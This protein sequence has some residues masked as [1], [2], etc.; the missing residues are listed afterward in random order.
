MTLQIKK[1][2]TIYQRDDGKLQLDGFDF[3]ADSTDFPDGNIPGELVLST[4]IRFIADAN[5]LTVMDI[6]H[7]K[8]SE[9]VV[10]RA[11]RRISDA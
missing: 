4:V 10:I 1:F 3:S 8:E 2:G 6:P 5:G 9:M 11:L 7:D